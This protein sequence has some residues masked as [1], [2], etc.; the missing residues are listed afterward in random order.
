MSER[1]ISIAGLANGLPG[2]IQTC[3]HGGEFLVARV[4]AYR[5]AD[6]KIADFLQMFLLHWD[7]QKDA[8]K[9]L[10]SLEPQLDED[11]KERFIQVLESLRR[12]LEK[13]TVTISKYTVPL[14]AS[15]AMISPS[16]VQRLRYALME[17][18]VL[19]ALET[20]ISAW[21]SRFVMR[22][23]LLVDMG[24][25]KSTRNS[26]VSDVVGT[27]SMR[28]PLLRR[29]GGTTPR[30][31]PELR[32]QEPFDKENIDSDL[33][34]TANPTV[35]VERYDGLYSQTPEEEVGTL[36]SS[37]HA[38]DPELM[39]ILPCI[40]YTKYDDVNSFYGLQFAFPRS[41]E[42]L[43]PRSLRR[44]LLETSP[45]HCLNDRL[46]I[47]SGI[48]IPEVSCIS[49][50]DQKQSLSLSRSKEPPGVPTTN[51]FP[52]GWDPVF[53][54]DSPDSVE[55][56]TRACP[57]DPRTASFHDIAIGIP[58]AGGWWQKRP[59]PCFTTYTVL[60]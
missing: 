38:A 8:L 33:F 26:E 7:F 27:I 28:I 22:L 1:A 54:P 13:A 21:Q 19:A 58:I 31:I 37:L 6:Q 4:T 41:T 43:R 56:R 18:K 48:F 11:V 39:H 60:V 5:Q 46:R 59:S 23:A 32:D 53:W 52:G 34:R 50:F 10:A 55:K 24:V 15:T 49:P 14:N 16:A 2:L 9:K 36:T 29:T 42:G 57:S 17:E 51:V 44:L 3:I 12:L 45:K 35:L 47:A 20:E 25:V 30:G 40:G